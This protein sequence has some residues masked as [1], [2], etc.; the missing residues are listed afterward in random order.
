[1]SANLIKTMEIEFMCAKKRILLI[2]LSKNAITFSSGN[3]FKKW[4]N[5]M[6][7]MDVLKILNVDGNPFCEQ[8]PRVKV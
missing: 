8:F 2:D 5:Y 6:K 3:E 1:M 4:I 7:S